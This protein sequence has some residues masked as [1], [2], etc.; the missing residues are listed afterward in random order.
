MRSLT[1]AS[2]TALAIGLGLTVF[3]T[4]WPKEEYVSAKAEETDTAIPEP[5]TALYHAYQV[6]K[7]LGPIPKFTCSDA[8]VIPITQN[9]VQ[10]TEEVDWCDNPA[11]FGEPCD[12]TN[13]VGRYQGTYENGDPRPEVIFLTFCRDGGLG[14]IGHNSETGATAF[15]SIEEG[16]RS[17]GDV[18]G[19]NDP[20][21]EKNWQPPAVVA[22][23]NCYKCHMADPWLHTPWI[24]QV[25][26]PE[27]PKESI[28][29]Y[30]A[31]KT[32]PY[33]IL[34]D[35]FDQ[36]LPQPALDELKGNSCIKCHRVQCIPE[37]FNYELGDITTLTGPLQLHYTDKMAD[38]LAALN[39]WCKAQ[40]IQYF[41][42]K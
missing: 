18:P 16:G 35:G 29:P 5:G 34:G 3:S 13:R 37:F 33:Y 19:P 9:G 31:D 21:Y 40:D 38:D 39:A 11:V 25:R 30:T 14:V 41:S 22:A 17:Y 7:E 27:N 15:F 42:G 23:D 28:I 26:N 4:L 20:G 1:K 10:V 2:I 32:S 24:D 6:A 12:P 8:V 36:P